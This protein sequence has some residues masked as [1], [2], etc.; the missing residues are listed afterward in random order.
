MF[1]F[2]SFNHVSVYLFNESSLIH[3]FTAVE[4]IIINFKN[5]ENITTEEVRWPTIKDNFGQVYLVT[6][7][8]ISMLIAIPGNIL[9]PY[10]VIK[11]TRLGDGACFQCIASVSLADLF[12]SSIGQPLIV[13]RILNTNADA[14]W[15]MDSF[16]FAVIWGL[17]CVSGFGVL[18]L[19]FERYLYFQYPL[20]YAR[21][22]TKKR[23]K[24]LIALQWLLGIGFGV[25]PLIYINAKLWNGLSLLTLIVINVFMGAVYYQIQASIK[26][27]K[28]KTNPNRICQTQSTRYKKANKTTALFFIIIILFCGFWYPYVTFSFVRCYYKDKLLDILLYWGVTVGC[29]NSSVN[30][31]IYGTTNIVLRQEIK[32]T[33]KSFRRNRNTL[34]GVTYASSYSFDISFVR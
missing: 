27:Q 32:R 5:M 9:I 22:L 21:L 3:L 29:F 17:C 7:H 33:L 10:T 1:L 2:Y 30:I 12:V 28:A 8:I 19:T 20:Q 6:F 23:T 16:A 31:F 26:K 15:I 14:N 4:V 11:S 13:N 25:L 24:C 34:V 18:C